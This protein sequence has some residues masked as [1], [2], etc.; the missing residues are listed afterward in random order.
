M[1]YVCNVL[2]MMPPAMM[3]SILARESQEENDRQQNNEQHRDAK[4]HPV[5]QHR[6]QDARNRVT[7][8]GNGNATHARIT[9]GHRKVGGSPTDSGHGGKQ[10]QNPKPDELPVRIEIHANEGYNEK[11]KACADANRGFRRVLS[12]TVHGFGKRF[13]RAGLR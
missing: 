12:Q 9:A 3:T 8:D 5:T 11:D 1:S 6:A 2:M 10:K 13:D 4:N 7:D